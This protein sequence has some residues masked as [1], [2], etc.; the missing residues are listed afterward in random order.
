MRPART[1]NLNTDSVAGYATSEELD[2][3][4][5]VRSELRDYESVAA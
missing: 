3:A 1:G 4:D 5:I 2:P